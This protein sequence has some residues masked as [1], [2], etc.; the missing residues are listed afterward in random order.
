MQTSALLFGVTLI[1]GAWHANAEY[2]IGVGIADVTGPPAEVIF[3]GYAKLTQKGEGLHLRQF[4]RA[5]IIDDGIS[6]LTFVSADIGMMGHALRRV[7]LRQLQ[8][9]Y[10]DLLYNEHNVILSG[11]HTHGGPGGYLMDVVFDITCLGFVQETF[12]AI[13]DGIVK[14]IENAHNKMV[15]GE[16]YYDVGQVLDANINRSPSAYDQ[17]PEEEK[18]EYEHNVDKELYQLKFKTKDGKPIGVINWFAV[19]PT[20]MN[21]TNHLVTSDN[22][23]YAAILFEDSMNNGALPGRGEFVAAFASANLGDVSPNIKG[24]KCINT[25]ENCDRNTSTCGGLATYCIASGPGNDIYESTSI[26]ANRIFA[27][28][29]NVFASTGRKISGPI[30]SIHQFVNMPEQTV[31]ITDD[32]GQKQTVKGCVPAMGYSFAA[33]TTD[34]P[35]EFDFQQGTVTSNEF[36]NLVRDFLQQPEPDDIECHA[37]KPILLATGRMKLPYDWQPSIL[38]T[39]VAMIGDLVIAAIP[40]E[41]TTMSGRRMRKALNQVAKEVSGVDATVIIAGLSNTYTDY[42]TTFEEYQVQR[43]EGASTIYGP[44]TLSIHMQQYRKL[45]KALLTGE[46]IPEGPV[47]EDATDKQISF[48]TPVILDLPEIKRHFGDCLVQP[49]NEYH[50][51]DTVTVQFMSGHPRNNLRHGGSYLHVERQTEDGWEVVATDASW[52]T[53]FW[54]KR[55]FLASSRVTIYWHITERYTPGIY[56]ISHMGHSKSPIN[57]IVPYEGSSK[58]FA[59]FTS[60]RIYRRF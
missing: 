11:T 58:P 19:H 17:N 50:I 48:V 15:D 7:I 28:A 57:G 23:G 24:A 40:G 54:W 43:Y 21:N 49:Q 2:K 31:E 59:V 29:M 33:G 3:M 12:D 35:G 13:V 22:V 39:Q 26:I 27:E 1:M 4:A 25:G 41:F 45:L 34:G 55:T 56:R 14:A 47:P 10:G 30:K 52:D 32:L 6:R 46:S 16:I 53:R 60:N 36:W 51:G 5:F 9:K 18:A 38:S 42:I 20:S 8:E 37:P 44:H